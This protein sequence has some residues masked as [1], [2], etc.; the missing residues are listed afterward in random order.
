MKNNAPCQGKQC[1]KGQVLIATT[2]QCISSQEKYK[3]PTKVDK[4]VKQISK[5]EYNKIRNLKNGG[6]MKTKMKKYQ[7]GGPADAMLKAMGKKPVSTKKTMKYV[8]KHGSGY[9]PPAGKKMQSGGTSEG[10]GNTTP[11]E[12]FKPGMKTGG[13]VNPNANLQAGKVAG[14]K[15]VKS[16]VNPKAAASKVA[17]GRSGG[18]SAAP[19]TALPKAQKGGWTV[20]DQKGKYGS[21]AIAT[22]TSDRKVGGMGVI[23]GGTKTKTISAGPVA[24]GA[25]GSINV[26]KTNNEGRETSSKTKYISQSRANRMI[27]RKRG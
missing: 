22:K 10:Y 8:K 21:G 18:T 25:K 12:K 13:M 9:I 6:T 27:N 15:G 4:S 26:T 1:P 17:R 2:C 16:G 14:S 11:G 19:K 24:P 7:D 20:D 5:E 3:S 23:K